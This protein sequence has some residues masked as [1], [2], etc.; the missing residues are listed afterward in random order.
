MESALGNSAFEPQVPE[1]FV[2]HWLLGCSNQAGW[3]DRTL[4]WWQLYGQRS[5]NNQTL[6]V[7][8]L[9]LFT[10]RSRFDLWR[11]LG[12]LQQEIT[13]QCRR[14]TC[15]GAQWWSVSWFSAHII[16]HRKYIVRYIHHKSQQWT[17]W[18]LLTY[19]IAWGPLPIRLA[20]LIFGV[21]HRLIIA[22]SSWS[23]QSRDPQI[24]LRMW[25]W[26]KT[27]K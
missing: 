20:T 2:S 19:C 18:H 4:E 9:L 3:W 23:Q 13:W 24:Y 16:R 12:H 21:V 15:G 10:P 6:Q 1:W 14:P 5:A 8:E 25:K 26:R 11:K 7:S 22:S 27:R 17:S